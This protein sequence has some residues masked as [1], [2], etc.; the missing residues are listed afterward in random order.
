MK[1]IFT[2]AIVVSLVAL[3]GVGIVAAFPFG[4]GFMNSD[5]TDEEKA[6]M[7][8]SQAEMK[9]AIQNG[10]Y[11]AWKGLMEE[12]LA[13]M[14]GQLTGENFQRIRERHEKMSEFNEVNA[15]TL[16]A[17]RAAIESGDFETAKE[18]REELGIEGGMHLGGRMP[19]C[20]RFREEAEQ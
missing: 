4:E 2:I 3:L 5:L 9:Q 14:K 6:E 11:Q 7:K 18:L 10:D 20:Q 12:R 19:G 13:K 16:E 8:Q 1:K 15:E 17:I